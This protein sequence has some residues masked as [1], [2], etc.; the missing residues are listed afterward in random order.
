MLSRR[1]I[2]RNRFPGLVAEKLFI[3]PALGE[4]RRTPLFLPRRGWKES[5][6]RPHSK[7][8][9]PGEDYDRD[10]KA[11]EDGPGCPRGT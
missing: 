1:V 4:A 5:Q 8:P 3:L 9:W 10:A 11:E 6:R 2:S 7:L